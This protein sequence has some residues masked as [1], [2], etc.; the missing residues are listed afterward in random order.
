MEIS[1]LTEQ[2]IIKDSLTQRDQ[3]V[4]VPLMITIH[5]A[6]W[7]NLTVWQPTARARGH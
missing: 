2:N 1:I 4:S 3:K 7:L 5:I 6:T